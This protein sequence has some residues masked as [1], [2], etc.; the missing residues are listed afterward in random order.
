MMELR[1]WTFH[2]AATVMFFQ[3]SETNK[4]IARL[5]PLLFGEESLQAWPRMPL[6]VGH[7]QPFHL[8]A[9]ILAAFT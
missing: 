7:I 8:L 5:L 3:A 1:Q 4:R 9:G 2:N 6:R